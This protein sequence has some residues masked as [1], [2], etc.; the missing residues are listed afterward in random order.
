MRVLVVCFL[1]LSQ[2]IFGCTGIMLLPDDGSVM[3][4]RTVEFGMPLDL[5]GAFV[6]RQ[7]RF[8]GQAPNGN[9]LAYTSRY[10]A[11]GC[12][13]FSEPVLMDGMNEKGLVAAAFYFPGYAGY[14]EITASNQQKALSPVDFPNWILTQFATVEEVKEGVK[15]VVIAPTVI[16]GWGDTPP[17]FHYIVY[18]Q[19]GKS[20]VIEPIDGRLI[21]HE[22]KIGAFTNSPTFDWHMT[23]LRNF[24]NLH[25]V[26]APPIE[27]RGVTFAPFGQGSG[28][29]GLPGD[30]TPPSRF[31][32][33]S[34]FSTVAKPTKGGKDTVNQAFHILNQFDI[35]VGSVQDKQ[36]GQV[37][38]DYTMMTS[39][40]DPQNLIYYFKSYRDPTIRFLDLKAFDPNGKE[41][42][43]AEFEQSATFVDVSAELK[44][45]L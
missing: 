18:D 7:I 43:S 17:P 20:I 9:G 3:T 38:S 32:R 41:I 36:N 6:P 5:H 44:P 19:T 2:T 1:C 33:A 22:N 31:V 24:I 26:D 14:A 40:K 15:D 12:F 25:K 10:S 16:E 4:G 8:Q 45:R 42:K 39:V 21:V 29:V 11:V 28:M 34:I 27:V 35:P 37:H 13:C 30:F 23:N